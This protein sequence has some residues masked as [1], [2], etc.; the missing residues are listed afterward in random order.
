[1]PPV[2]EFNAGSRGNRIRP[3]VPITVP[4][5]RVM[6]GLGFIGLISPNILRLLVGGDAAR[7]ASVT[8]LSGATVPIWA[9]IAACTLTRDTTVTR[10]ESLPCVYVMLYYTMS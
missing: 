3:P 7:V 2:L 6:S 1:M 8:V 5:G 4:P 10:L 9:D